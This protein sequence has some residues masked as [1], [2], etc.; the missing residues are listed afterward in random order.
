MYQPITLGFSCIISI[1]TVT[2]EGLLL[3]NLSPSYL[4]FSTT[5]VVQASETILKC[6]IILLKMY[7]TLVSIFDPLEMA[8]ACNYP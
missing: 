5:I 8:N 7:Y 1:N 2:S 6:I 4:D 3:R